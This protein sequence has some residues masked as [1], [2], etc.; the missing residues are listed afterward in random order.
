MFEGTTVSEPPPLVI[1]VILTSFS[2]L[3]IVFVA[4][5]CFYCSSD[6][7]TSFSVLFSMAVVIAQHCF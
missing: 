3:R 6:S 4:P 5:Y 7:F 1:F 2:L